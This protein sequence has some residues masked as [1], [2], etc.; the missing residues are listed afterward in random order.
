MCGTVQDLIVQVTYPTGVYKRSVLLRLH[1]VLLIMI[2][3]ILIIVVANVVLCLENHRFLGLEISTGR[4]VKQIT[5]V[6]LDQIT[7]LNFY[8]QDGIQKANV[9]KNRVVPNNSMEIPHVLD[10][11]TIRDRLLLV[12]LN[13]HVIYVLDQI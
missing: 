10:V 3:K 5:I 8:H 6:I 2:V 12:E 9:L 13:Q 7:F 11:Q 4:H 1:C